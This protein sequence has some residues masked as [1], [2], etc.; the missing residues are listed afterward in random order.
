[1]KRLKRIILCVAVLLAGSAAQTASSKGVILV[2]E[3]RL[4]Q[5]LPATVF[6]DGENV[7]T[8][9]RNAALV[10]LPDGKILLASL[11]DTAGYSSA[12]QQKYAGVLLSQTGFAIG[13]KNFAAGAYAIGQKKNGE[14]VTMYVYNLGGEQLAELPTEKQENLRPLKPLQVIAAADGSARLYLGPYYLSLAGR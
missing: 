14:S 10:Q 9:E 13:S 7:P 3:Q 1:M 8:Q 11:V 6:I 5:L 12:Y 2:S 4:K